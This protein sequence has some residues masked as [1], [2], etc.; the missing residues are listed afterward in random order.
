MLKSCIEVLVDVEAFIVQ[1]HEL[2]A[3]GITPDIG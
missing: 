2:L 3:G 1:N